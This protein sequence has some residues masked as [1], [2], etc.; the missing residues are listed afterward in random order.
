MP[1]K[2]TNQVVAPRGVLTFAFGFGNPRLRNC[3][4]LGNCDPH[5]RAA[6]S[7]GEQTAAVAAG[8]L[9]AY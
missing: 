7:R 8:D 4:D 2:Q 3:D 6:G 1:L 5:L 9:S